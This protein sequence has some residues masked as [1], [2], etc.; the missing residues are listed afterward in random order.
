MCGYF[1]T[2]FIDFLLSGKSLIHYTSFFSLYN[3]EENDNIIFNYF[4]IEWTN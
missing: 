1:C 2:E 3:F 4:K